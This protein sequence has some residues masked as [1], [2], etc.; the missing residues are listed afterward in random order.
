MH[1]L[2][3]YEVIEGHLLL[4]AADS[5]FKTYVA[6][7]ENGVSSVTFLRSTDRA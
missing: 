5:G 7:K 2:Y 3:T 4:A 1:A 6:G